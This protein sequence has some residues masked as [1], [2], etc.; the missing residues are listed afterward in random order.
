MLSNRGAVNCSTRQR[1]RQGEHVESFKSHH[2]EPKGDTWMNGQPKNAK[3][4]S[5]E[6]IKENV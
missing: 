2:S 1:E 4:N 6:N 5:G 3:R